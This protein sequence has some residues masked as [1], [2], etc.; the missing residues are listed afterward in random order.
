VRLVD[1]FHI[2]QDYVRFDSGHGQ[3][4][5]KA[6]EFHDDPPTPRY[7]ALEAGATLAHLQEIR[8]DGNRRLANNRK[9]ALKGDDRN[10][11]RI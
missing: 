5:L 8:A 6:K 2:M 4:M 1:L 3:L 9:K 11:V 7:E 10:N